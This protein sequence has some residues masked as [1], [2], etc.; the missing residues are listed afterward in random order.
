MQ[1][2]TADL[3]LFGEF[4]PV[5]KAVWN[6]QIEKDLK[7]KDPKNLIKINSD[8]IQ[9]N[10]FY[11]EE[12]LESILI[13][14]CIP[15]DF[16]F[17]RG[18]RKK[19]NDW[20]IRQNIVVDNVEE[21]NVQAL[22]ALRRGATS[23]GFIVSDRTL[24]SQKS[25]DK[26][27]KGIYLDKIRVNFFA[28]SFAPDCLTMLTNYSESH[29][30]YLNSIMGSVDFSPL[31]YLNIHGRFYFDSEKRSMERAKRIILFS[32]QKLP[33][34]RVLT[35][36]GQYYNQAGASVSQELAFSLSMANEYLVWL[37]NEGVSVDTVAQRMQFNFEIGSD[38]F[39]EIAKIRAA[40]ILW[41]KILAQYK[42]QKLEQSAKIFINAFTSVWNKT[43]Y[44]P[45]VNILRAT[46]ETMSAAI[47]GADTITVAPFDMHF[48]RPDALSERIARN[49]QHLLKQES[50]LNKVADPGAGSYYIEQ[51]TK[52]LAEKAWELFLEVEENGGYIEAFKKGIIQKRIQETA[53]KK[54]SDIKK[55]KHVILGVNQYPN[56]YE[57]QSQNIDS[58]PEPFEDKRPMIAEPLKLF[59]AASCFE[60]LRLA[61]EQSGKRPKV[62]IFK[63][64]SPVMRSARANFA[65]NF[66]G[67]AGFGIIEKD[68]TD[69]IDA[70]IDEMVNSKP[71][72][73]VLC[74]SDEEYKELAPK[75]MEKLSSDTIPVVA[76]YP[77]SDLEFLENSGIK[78]Y[79][80]VKSNIYDELVEYQKLLKII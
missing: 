14:N 41:A 74:S 53:D 22:S 47:G 35:M 32:E 79:I 26:L 69:S 40:R 21:A 29:G 57:I 46:T 16:P 48:R 54:L 65:K 67:V 6:E 27:M 63:Y 2:N 11:T 33:K 5:T 3:N 7:G 24:D 72:I 61:T 49:I 19:D 78:H 64:G 44:D 42:P 45:Y 38:F 43:T 56:F 51:L 15:G 13:K 20:D 50:F 37:T 75:I 71:E 36:N 58:L 23:L 66:F 8:G 68:M 28:G 59:R 34:F 55:R 73:L 18:K 60:E 76:G 52:E 1:N 80:H 4:N 25:F 62:W 70:S 39:L 17:L 31:R 12:D 30:L 10:P 9:I 77:K